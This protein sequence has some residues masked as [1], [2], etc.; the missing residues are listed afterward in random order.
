M[1]VPIGAGD[2]Q[3]MT[4]IIK[5]SETSYEKHE[6]KE[7]RFVPMLQDKAWGK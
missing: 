7:F 1:V 5:T 6:L 2:V 3:T 4:T